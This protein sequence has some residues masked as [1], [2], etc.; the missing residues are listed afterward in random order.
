MKK[1]KVIVVMP[2]WNEEKR[3]GRV[4]KNVKKNKRVDSIIVIDDGSTDKTAEIAKKM[5]AIVFSLKKHEKVLGPGI[6]T[7]YGLKKAVKSK[8][9][10]IILMDADGQHNPSDIPKFIEAI[11]EGYDTAIGARD[12]SKYPISRKLGNWGLT[13]ITNLICPLGLSDVEC[14]YKAMTADAFKKMNLQAARY[15]IQ[16]EFIYDVW[17]TRLSIKEVKVR[18]PVFYP[19]PAVRRGFGNLIYLLHRRYLIA[20]LF[21]RALRGLFKR[22]GTKRRK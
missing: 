3:I 9:D 4:L 14:G 11:E 8:A 7:I 10:I 16:M 22:M 6:P 15:Q 21:Y 2:A 17:K 5:G 13:N 18:V 1:N 12:L 19:K 20:K